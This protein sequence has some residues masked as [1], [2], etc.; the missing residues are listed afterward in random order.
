MR[1]ATDGASASGR[2]R[3]WGIITDSP[4]A[5]PHS[6]AKP[7]RETQSRRAAL[8]IAEAPVAQALRRLPSRGSGRAVQELPHR[9]LPFCHFNDFNKKLSLIHI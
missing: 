1:P 8:M 4:T 3:R 2:A 6:T 5:Q 7:V 9:L